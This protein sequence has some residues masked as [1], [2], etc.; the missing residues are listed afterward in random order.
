MDWRWLPGAHRPTLHALSS[1]S[2]SNLYLSAALF[3][4]SYRPNDQYDLRNWE[5]HYDPGVV[6]FGMPSGATESS[7]RI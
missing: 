1:S 3:L 5:V 4:G 6:Q 2:S 7:A